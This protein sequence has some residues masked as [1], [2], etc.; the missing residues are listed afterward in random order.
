L[1]VSVTNPN[2]EKLTALQGSPCEA[3]RACE[4]ICVKNHLN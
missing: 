1:V 2:R 3:S 4:M